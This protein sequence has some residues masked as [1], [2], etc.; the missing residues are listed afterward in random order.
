MIISGGE[1]VYSTEVEHVLY[2]H[3]AILEAAVI[4]VPH[5]V[6]GET[7]AAVVVP[8]KG[9]QI[10]HEELQQ[11]CRK[12]LAGYKIPRI[13]YEIDQLPRNTSGKVLKYMLKERLR[14]MT[15]KS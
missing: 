10:N 14:D 4:G 8:K 2:K 5:E 12:D 7:V 1:N 3:P 6:W 9:Q 13:F 15:I 11:F